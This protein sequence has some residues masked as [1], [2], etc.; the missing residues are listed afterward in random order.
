MRAEPITLRKRLV[1]E[2]LLAV[3]KML[4]DD[5]D[6][7]AALRSISNSLHF[8]LKEKEESKL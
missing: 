3:A 2:I 6:T 1:I 4:C 5:M 7:S 8:A